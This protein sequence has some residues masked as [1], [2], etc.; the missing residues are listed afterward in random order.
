[1]EVIVSFIERWKTEDKINEK[2]IMTITTEIYPS[3]KTGDTVVLQITNDG[4]HEKSMKITEYVIT[5]VIHSVHE[6]V[7]LHKGVKYLMGMEVHVLEV[8]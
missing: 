6:K 5:N 7:T 1:M 2:F 8:D 3:Y 4:N